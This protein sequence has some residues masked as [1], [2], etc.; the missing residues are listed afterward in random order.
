MS[1]PHALLTALIEQSSSGSELARRFDR[2]IGFFWSATH[3]QIYRELGRLEEAGWVSSTLAEGGR[4]GKKVYK[5]LPAGRRELKRWAN[6]GGDPRS[7]RDQLMVR[8][9]AEAVI[10]PTTLRADIERRLV[11]HRERLALYQQL[12]RT[13]FHEGEAQPDRIRHLIL[14]AG[15]MTEAFWADW[16]ELALEVLAEQPPSDDPGCSSAPTH[17]QKRQRQ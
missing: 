2:S 8:V 11:E 3:Q 6:A 7:Q 4:G 13:Q 10:G 9:R 15:I 14:T 1:L 16:S 17:T 12:E 5:V